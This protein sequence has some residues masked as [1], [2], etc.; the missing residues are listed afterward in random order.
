MSVNRRLRAAVLASALLLA[1]AGCDPQTATAPTGGTNLLIEFPDAQDLVRGHTVQL[2]NVRVGSVRAIDLIRSETSDDYAAQVEISIIDSVHI[3]VGT[4]AVL[5]RTSLLGEHFVDLVVPDGEPTAFYEDGDRIEHAEVLDDFEDVALQASEVLGAVAGNDLTTIVD[6]AHTALSGR[7]RQLH[8][9]IGDLS[10]VVGVIADQRADLAA[11]ID[12]LAAL[13]AALAPGSERVGALID[14]LAATTSL[15]AEHRGRIVTAL[16]DLTGL[17]TTM[18]DTVLEPHT[19]RL[20]KLL[21]DLDPVVA[22][23]AANRELVDTLVVDLLRF[24]EAVPAAIDD[25]GRLNAFAWLLLEG[26]M[27]ASSVAPTGPA[28]PLDATTSFVQSVQP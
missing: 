23:V 24:T 26:V 25:K 20:T 19:E 2:A 5:R 27:N 18:N 3:P 22:K 15:L 21:A 28:T 13:G 4:T 14:D 6:A 1:T 11:T 12:G 9:L 10:S 17:A 7:G 8:A 16:E